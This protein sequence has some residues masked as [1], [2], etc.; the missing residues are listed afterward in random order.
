VNDA[1]AGEGDD[2]SL[3]EIDEFE[4]VLGSAPL[5]QGDIFE[6]LDPFR[7]PPWRELAVI[8][9]ADCDMANSKIGDVVSFVPLLPFEDYIWQFWREKRFSSQRDRALQELESFINKR[10]LK[11]EKAEISID[12][13]RDWA[14]RENNEDIAAALAIT[15]INL[16]NK[17]DNLWRRFADM[18]ALLVTDQCDLQLLLKAAEHL[19]KPGQPA[20][21]F[22]A[23]D[24]Q[25]NLANLPGDVFY[26]SQVRGEQGGAFAML[27]QIRQCDKFD[28][29]VEPDQI[30]FA[31]AKARRIARLRPTFKYGLTQQLARVFSDIGLPAS[32]DGRVKNRSAKFFGGFSK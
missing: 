1:K 8:V 10:L 11:Q 23:I 13:V 5:R 17:L 14:G 18:N 6:W 25:N 32:Y 7:K 28:I 27:R 16:K 30:R 9:T 19:T 15:D 22:L 29:A 31:G 24:F 2:P 3:E 4:E 21:D 12:A 20:T 26:L